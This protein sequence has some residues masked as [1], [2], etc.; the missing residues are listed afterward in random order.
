MVTPFPLSYPTVLAIPLNY[1]ERSIKQLIKEL[2]FL[3]YFICT[4]HTTT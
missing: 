2:N 1:T 4:V 3:F